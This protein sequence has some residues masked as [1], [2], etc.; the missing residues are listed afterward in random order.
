MSERQQNTTNIGLLIQGFPQEALRGFADFDLVCD[1]TN[2]RACS[3]HS[4]N[5]TFD[6]N[7]QKYSVK[8]LYAIIDW[9]FQNNALWDTY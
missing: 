2:N 5:A 4:H 1:H 8:I 7:F 9:E 3:H 6:W